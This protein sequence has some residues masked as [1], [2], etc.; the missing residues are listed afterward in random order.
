MKDEKTAP[1]VEGAALFLRGTMALPASAVALE[2]RFASLNNVLIEGHCLLE[3]PSACAF[4]RR[5]DFFYRL[6][7]RA[8]TAKA[9]ARSSS[10]AS[11]P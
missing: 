1:S 6:R 5:A 4:T 3:A 2:N 10:T 8:M 9:A 7:T 11:H